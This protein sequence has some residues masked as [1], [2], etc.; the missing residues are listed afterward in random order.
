MEVKAKSTRFD[1]YIPIL[2]IQDGVIV[3]KRGELTVGWEMTLPSVCSTTEDGYEDMLESFSSS[4]RALGPG[5][6][7][8]R[9][10]IYLNDTYKAERKAH[11]LEQSYERHFDGRRHLTHR[12]FLYLTLVIDVCHQTFFYYRIPIRN[13]ICFSS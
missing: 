7:I 6:I 3:S 12:Q 1:K 5:F 2:A 11:F 13:N 10:D 8:H 9:Q 4:I